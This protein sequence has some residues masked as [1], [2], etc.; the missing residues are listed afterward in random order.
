MCKQKSSGRRPV[1]EEQIDR[2][3]GVYQR[4][5]G[6]STTSSSLELQI[7]NPTVRKTL[8]KP[9]KLIPYKLQLVQS[10]NNNDNVHVRNLVSRYTNT[11]NFI[12]RLVFGNEC[13]FHIGGKVNGHNVRI[14]GRENA[15]ETVHRVRDS[16]KVNVCIVLSCKT[17]WGIFYSFLFSRKNSNRNNLCELAK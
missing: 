1:S 12:N 2:V 8:R 13:M 5:P 7:P 11:L 15:R 14:W 4:N 16:S 9:L 10:L 17:V 6:K 3:H